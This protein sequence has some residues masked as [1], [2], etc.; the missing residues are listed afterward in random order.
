MRA[1][2]ELPGGPSLYPV[3]DPPAE[4]SPDAREDLRV[5]ARLFELLVLRRHTDALLARLEHAGEIGPGFVAGRGATAGIGIAAALE[6]GDQVFGTR[7]DWPAA[8]ARGLDLADVLG[9]A[10][11]TAGGIDAGAAGDL[12]S[13][14]GGFHLTDA[15]TA[16]HVAEAVGYG[17]AARLSGSSAIAVCFL[18]SGT[19]MLPETTAALMQAVASKARVAFVLRGPRAA[20]ER[21]VVIHRVAVPADSAWRAYWALS[22]ARE[23]RP[24]L[25]V[26][27]D[28]RHGP[29]A[30]APLDA[31]LL[32][33]RGILSPEFERALGTE[34]GDRLD[35]VRRQV[36]AARGGGR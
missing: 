12:R 4:G 5:L 6:P 11:R 26:L 19:L 14:E 35:E 20:F 29:E 13:Q 16:S 7:R 25:P 33:E 32:R 23:A 21:L 34:V 28:A 9:R 2:D 30:E 22:E 1:P 18:G 3:P 36:M 24:G 17:L 27:I 8:L 10:M 15:T 31:E